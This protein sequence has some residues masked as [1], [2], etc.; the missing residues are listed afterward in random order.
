[1]CQKWF[2]PDVEAE[3]LEVMGGAVPDADGLPPDAIM[4]RETQQVYAKVNQQQQQ[5]QPK[6]LAGQ[7]TA[8]NSTGHEGPSTEHMRRP[9]T[10]AHAQLGVERQRGHFELLAINYVQRY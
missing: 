3:E 5:Q 10:I 6:K 4:R 2:L 7:Q 1:M 8:G 9:D